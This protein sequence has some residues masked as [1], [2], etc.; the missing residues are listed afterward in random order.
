[1]CIR[2]CAIVRIILTV[3]GRGKHVGDGKDLQESSLSAAALENEQ[4]INCR[5]DQR[6]FGGLWSSR[7]ALYDERD[8]EA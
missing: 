4:Q 1:M 5:A 6:F 8:R 2:S 7:Q 3:A